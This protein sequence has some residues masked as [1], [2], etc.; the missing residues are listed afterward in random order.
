MKKRYLLV[1]GVLMFL[2]AVTAS[3]LMRSQE[4][5]KQVTPL[6][7]ENYLYIEEFEIGPGM[8]M[9]KAIAE[10]KDSV[11]GMRKTGEFK[12]VRLYIHNTGPRFAVYI[13]AEPKSWQSIET[14]FAKFLA[15]MPDFGD[16]PVWFTHS[17]NLVSEI[18]VE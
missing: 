7:G 17:D 11:R 12:S 15:T 9:N 16:R 13:L 6:I 5:K 1:A 18:P 2:L 10:S 14:G 8:T 4:T 3:P